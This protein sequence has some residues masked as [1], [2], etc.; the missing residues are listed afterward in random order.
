MPNL[1]HYRT[2]NLQ[3]GAGEQEITRAYRLLCRRYHPDL[4]PN[5][6]QAAQTMAQINRS[7]RILKQA[8]STHTAETAL[9]APSRP[10]PAYTETAP[11]APWLQLTYLFGIAVLLSAAV[12]GLATYRQAAAASPLYSRSE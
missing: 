11:P 6:P 1:C 9:P 5:N 2:L 10:R 4:H 7:Y 12:Y 3:P 8:L